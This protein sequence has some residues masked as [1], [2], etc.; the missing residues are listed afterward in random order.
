[1]RDPSAPTCTSPLTLLQLDDLETT[2]QGNT[3]VGP[4]GPCGSTT[5]IEVAFRH[6]GWQ[7]RR[8]HVLD[9]F[10]RVDPL[11]SRAA[12]FG[13]CGRNAWVVESISEPGVYR[14]ACSKCRDRLCVPC[15]RARSR[16]VAARV[17]EL[18]KDR[19]IRFL[20][21][22]LRINYAPLGD[23][24]T[25]LISCFARLRRRKMWKSTQT[26]GV[27]FL[28]LKRRPDSHTWHPH[29]HAIIEGVF[30]DKDDISEAWHQI[31]G[32]S[33]IIKI[34][35]CDS[36][37]KAA[38]YAAKYSGKAV[39]NGVEN[40]P[41]MLDEAIV[42]LKG[43]RLLMCFGNWSF[44]DDVEDSY[45]DEWRAVGTLRSVLERAAA[46]D[47][48]ARTILGLLSGGESSCTEP[49]SPPVLGE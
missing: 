17:A 26:G 46:G 14:V 23:Q 16:R 35:K 24:V 42:A 9:A 21:L 2:V 20:T 6:S 1:M 37:A 48:A 33:F 27:A 41:E 10:E 34:K 47:L 22:T 45:P 32:D 3:A 49:R 38:Y 19:E 15:A 18:S 8:Q 31:T 12:R 11:S 25:R 4:L 28:E 44:P 39:H 43:R 40:D 13:A 29:I 36:S 7:N 5:D 30:L